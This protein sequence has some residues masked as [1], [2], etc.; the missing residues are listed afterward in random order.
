MLPYHAPRPG[1]A[2][3]RPHAP[4]LE[5]RPYLQA[6]GGGV[7]L[8]QVQGVAMAQADAV[9]PRAV[10][11]D[12]ARP[13]D[14]L[15][16]AVAVDIAHA[17]AVVSLPRVVALAADRRVEAPPPPKL[18]ARIVPRLEHR[19]AVDSAR[20]EHREALAVEAPGPDAVAAGPLVVA[21]APLL[22]R[23]PGYV[24]GAGQLTSARAI[25]DRDE[26]RARRYILASVYAVVGEA[27][28]VGVAYLGAVAKH[29]SLR[30]AHGHLG[31]S[32]AVE[33][34]H[35]K[36]R[37]VAQRYVRARAHPPHERAVEA[38]GLEEG[39]V[40]HVAGH[41]PLAPVG[42]LCAHLPLQYNLA[43][44]VAIKVA[45]ARIVGQVGVCGVHPGGCGE[46]H[47]YVWQPG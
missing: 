36:R 35:G 46:R 21:V 13:V 42:G 4:C 26:L 25:D 30:R 27:V 39:G 6:V 28:A 22:A 23:A 33:V 38:V 2:Q 29:R 44:A 18:S 31:P 32:V 5:A 15:V 10:V 14:H 34:G 20:D 17:Q 43:N 3:G 12:G 24:V 45:H 41:G 37:R 7:E 11:V 40:A 9:E 47:R 19:L 16:E 1:V 8:A